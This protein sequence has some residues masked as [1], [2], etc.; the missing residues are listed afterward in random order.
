[1]VGCGSIG[2]RHIA[3]ILSLGDHAVRAVDVDSEAARDVAV[4]YGVPIGTGLDAA[5]DERPDCVFITTPTASHLGPAM[6]AARAGCDLFVE[7]PLSHSLDGVKELIGEVEER[8]LITMV[9]CNMRFHPNIA[10]MKIFLQEG[11][12]GR[13]YSVHAE[14]GSY[15][16][17]WR[18]SVDYRRN[19]GARKELGGGVLLDSIHEL[20]Y[21]RWLIGEV[22][23]V[24]CQAGKVSSLEIDT[25]DLA[26]VL[27]RFGNGALGT[28]HL[29]YLQ[30]A[31]SRHC[32]LIGE[33]GVLAWDMNRGSVDF[34]D[35][36]VGA[37][38]EVHRTPSDF[39]VNQ[40][41]LGEIRAFFDA[42]ETRRVPMS[43]VKEAARVLELTVRCKEVAGLA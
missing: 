9:G 40:L 3:N 22:V 29:D 12:L 15:L 27:I 30:R 19:Y 36:G 5:L 37:W 42:V 39:A 35:N 25:E 6:A 13:I 20:D 1:M 32:K 38:R 34:Y 7:K 8:K 4:R 24:Q 21:L 33:N 41:Y 11:R 17:G 43:D 14:A 10:A 28:L 18:P 23:E 2:K 26:V 16:P 31:Y